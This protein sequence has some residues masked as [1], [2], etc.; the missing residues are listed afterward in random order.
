M[1]SQQH[2]RRSLEAL[3][4]YYLAGSYPG[5]A[6]AMPRKLSCYGTKPNYFFTGSW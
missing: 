4:W 6:Q 2:G 5:I 3:G 1:L